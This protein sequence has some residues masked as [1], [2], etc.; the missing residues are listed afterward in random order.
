[1]IRVYSPLASVLISA[2]TFCIIVTSYLPPSH[3]PSSLLL[4]LP[5]TLCFCSRFQ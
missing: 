4:L 2:R 5:R 1:M 3:L